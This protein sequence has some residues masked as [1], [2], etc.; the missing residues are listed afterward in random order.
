MSS[1]ELGDDHY[2]FGCY[3]QGGSEQRALTE[4]RLKD[5]QP[6][7]YTCRDAATGEAQALDLTPGGRY[8]IGG[9]SGTY[10]VS[11]LTSD[12]GG[13]QINWLTGPFAEQSSYYSEE[14]DNGFRSFNLSLSDGR[15]VGGGCLQLER[16]LSKLRRRGRAHE[17]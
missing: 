3:Q 5:P 12:N 9:V 10:Q 8:S 15:A 1:V 14:A 6:G 7:S 17:L 11:D 13:S 16:T 4:F 2:N